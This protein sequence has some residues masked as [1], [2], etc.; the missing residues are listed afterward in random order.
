MQI[1]GREMTSS[2]METSTTSLAC[3][4]VQDKHQTKNKT[5]LQCSQ[6]LYVDLDHPVL[7]V[8]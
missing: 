7:A 6:K 2:I 5:P 3:L 8:S 1:E 4:T